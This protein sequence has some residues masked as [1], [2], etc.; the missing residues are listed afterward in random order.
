VEGAHD[1]SVQASTISFKLSPFS[2]KLRWGWHWSAVASG[3]AL[4]IAA[5][6]RSVQV[7]GKLS[8]LHSALVVLLPGAVL[9]LVGAPF[10]AAGGLVV[11][12]W[13][14]AYGIAH[15]TFA[16]WVEDLGRLRVESG[17]RAAAT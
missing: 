12:G 7:T 3:G 2:M 13:T 16:P 6:D 8:L 9:L 10:W 17:H 4:T 15:V 1:V 14:F 5:D 11:G